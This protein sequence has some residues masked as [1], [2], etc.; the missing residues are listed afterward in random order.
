[1]HQQ[2]ILFYKDVHGIVAINLCKYV[3]FVTHNTRNNHFLTFIQ[4]QSCTNIYGYSFYLRDRPKSCI[5]DAKGNRLKG[6]GGRLAQEPISYF[7]IRSSH[8]HVETNKMCLKSISLVIS[9]SKIRF[10]VE[11]YKC[12]SEMMHA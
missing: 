8:T 5:W 2:L 1:M 6:G 7:S 12:Q 9:F 10:G 4:M 11:H 3:I